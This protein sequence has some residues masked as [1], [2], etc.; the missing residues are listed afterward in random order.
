MTFH[1]SVDMT[2]AL[3]LLWFF[4]YLMGRELDWLKKLTAQERYWMLI[5]EKFWNITGHLRTCIQLSCKR[6]VY[7]VLWVGGRWECKRHIC[8]M[9]LNYSTRKQSLVNIG[10]LICV[11]VW[12]MNIWNWVEL[13]GNRRSW[14]RSQQKTEEDLSSKDSVSLEKCPLKMQCPPL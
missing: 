6:C 3:I 2:F 13:L 10:T 12:E 14:L 9:K 1:A 7:K 8:I 11:C 5:C 4:W